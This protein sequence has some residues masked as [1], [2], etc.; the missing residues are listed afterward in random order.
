MGLLFKSLLIFSIL[1][2]V[3]HAED[4]KI[5]DIVIS[6]SFLDEKVV[7][8]AFKM[9][10]YRKEMRDNIILLSDYAKEI[11]KDFIIVTRQGGALLNIGAW[12]E[13]LE[14][15]KIAASRGVFGKDD[16]FI[17]KM[18]NPEDMNTLPIGTPLSSYSSS[19]DGIIEDIH[20]CDNNV[21]SN[22]AIKE[23]E[24]KGI[25]RMKIRYCENNDKFINE[26]KNDKFLNNFSHD[27]NGEFSKIPNSEPLFVNS[28]NV[29]GLRDAK[30]ML[31]LDNPKDFDNKSEFLMK[32]QDT[33]YDLLVVSA[34]FNKK[35]PL[36]KEDVA[37]LKYKKI[38]AKRLVF[39]MMDVA[40]MG[41]EDFYFKKE[42]TLK[43]PKW[44]VFMDKKYPSKYVVEY[45]NPDFKRILGKYFKGIMDLGFDGVVFNGVDAHFVFEKNA[46]ID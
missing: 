22:E 1:T 23:I 4:E 18:F 28:D 43:N 35:Q 5:G 19:I 41:E 2:N 37:S 10:N 20:N 11:N 15:Y 9:P 12:E 16:V 42:F 21:L 33:N 36:I 25:V 17:E 44:I 46:G 24:N 39:A 7:D 6:D 8:D 31:V 38:G 30:N 26:I 3:V 27:E 29:K 34:F 45:F 13:H 14:E 32:L 40:R